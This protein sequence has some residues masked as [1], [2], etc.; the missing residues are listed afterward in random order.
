M[1]RTWTADYETTFNR[2]TW[3]IDA[4]GHKTT[5]TYDSKGNLTESRSKAN[6]GTQPHA[7][8]H[9]I[10]ITHQYDSY[11]NRTKTT[12][13]PGTSEEKVVE[14]VY[15]STHHTYPIEVKTTVTVD[16]TKKAIKTK[17]EWDTNRGLK[18]ADID[19]MGRRTEY[20]YW[21]DR[22]LKYTKRVADNMYTV[23]T[24]DKQGNLTQTQVRKTNWQTGTLLAQSKTEYDGMNRA[25]K[26]HRYKDDWTTPYAT[27]TTTYDIYGQVSQSKD[28]RNLITTLTLDDLGRV[29]KK[30][31]PDGDWAETRYN[32]LGQVSKAWTSATGTESSPAVSYTY[33]A[34]Y[35][36]LTQVNYKNGESVSYTY[37]KG[38]NTLTLKTNDG[39]SYPTDGSDTFT[40]TYTY[41]QLN[42]LK[43][44]KNPHL[45]YKTFY[46]YDDAS[47]PT[48]M[49]IQPTEGGAN[50]YDVRYTYDE[51]IRMVSVRD[52]IANKTASYSYFDNG[53]IKTT[54]LPNG[55]TAHQTLDT[56]NRLD[57][58]QYK[59][60]DAATVLSSLDYTYDDKSNV[61][62]L[63]R[64][65]TGAGGSSK[66][67][68]FGYDNISRLTSANYG[69][70]TASYT[71]DKSGNRLTQV[72]SVDGTTTYT[73]AAN[74]NQLNS[75][76]LV[77]ED[78]DFATMTYTYDAEGK[79]TKRADGNNYDTFTHV[80]G[81][82]VKQIEKSRRGAQ[83][84]RRAWKYDG[85]GNRIEEIS[86]T[87][88][89]QPTSRYF[90]Y[91][92]SRPVLELNAQKQVEYA[93]LYGANGVVYRRKFIPAS[94]KARW[95]FDDASGT[96][97]TD[98]VG[99]NDGT[100]GGGTATKEP[101]WSTENG[102]SLQ[103]DGT[104]DLVKVDDSDALDFVGNTL[105]ISGW[106]KRDTQTSGN[107]VKKADASNGYRLWITA[108]GNL[109][110]E[111]LKAGTTHTLTSAQTIPLNTWTHV[112]ARYNSHKMRIFIAGVRDTA[113]TD[114]V[115][116]FVATTEP[117]YLGY[118]DGTDHHFDG[119]LSNLA[120]YKIA[121][122]GHHIIQLS[123][124]ETGLYEYHH[125]N[126]LGSPIVLTDGAEGVAARYEY[127]VFGE[128]RSESGSSDNVR[129]FTGKEYDSY[130]KLHYFDARYYD[131][132]TG[133]FISRDPAGD[134]LNWYAYAMNN[135]LAFIDPTGTRIAILGP[136][137][138][139]G[140]QRI[141][142]TI[143][144]TGV[145]YAPGLGPHTVS[146]EASL[147]FPAVQGTNVGTTTKHPA[148]SNIAKVGELGI[149]INNVI[150][151]DKL[152]YLY[153]DPSMKKPGETDF[154]SANSD[155]IIMTRIGGEYAQ[156]NNERIFIL[157][158]IAVA[159]ELV[160]AHQAIENPANF[161]DRSYY[162]VF[163]LEYEAY[164]MVARM[165]SVIEGDYTK[166]L[167]YVPEHFL[168]PKRFN[169]NSLDYR[170]F[171]NDVARQSAAPFR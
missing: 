68:S 39:T 25:V 49:Y 35:N 21:Q 171:I 100:L 117:L 122:S 71:Y 103:F 151:S 109:Q 55:V 114:V 166:Y 47:Q 73:I 62:Q 163:D 138:A 162:N 110:F 69:D 19:S 41:D 167:D 123:K 168:N 161:R 118:Y 116:T 101:A 29:T 76:S 112:S 96:T 150:N 136:P 84:H 78:S 93:Y 17:A 159:H 46:E 149:M 107:L 102:G 81:D 170:I 147:L 94:A 157:L 165:A 108:A 145:T 52:A 160:H 66:T 50:V 53:V 82:Q 154:Y 98:E 44:W 142:V 9:D 115:T 128:V 88:G 113:F 127:D 106:V 97:L 56:L 75:R 60:S 95:R 146:L 36:R 22:R 74:S 164:D 61:T 137:D 79:L 40:Y 134:G 64:D 51:L 20:V 124:G 12:F 140:Q 155:D 126:A 91:D 5:F 38:G 27:T 152:V 119:Y 85:I 33:D 26:A 111:I 130:S 7:V 120:I 139:N 72:S 86:H 15:D 57:T 67:F 135:P 1:L 77:P 141:E 90:L 54:T 99:D 30:L 14:T 59:K 2:P 43:T 32:S 129:T 148:L 131:A 6:T 58:L 8:D 158:R 144:S 87:Y 18:T 132:Y 10:V 133:R 80:F 45:G 89:T 92:G 3:Q 48:R 104:D 16:G 42:R 37:D 13:M 34:K 105:T 11:G 83:Q 65:D 143:D 121:L 169:P 4:M 63:V 24:H 125:A 23:P 153:F 31:L 156:P 28:A 70:E